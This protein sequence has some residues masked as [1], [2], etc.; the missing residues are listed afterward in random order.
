MRTEV[1]DT[2]GEGRWFEFLCI[3]TFPG[4]SR[5]FV[6]QSMS[7]PYSSWFL[8]IAV[9]LAPFFFQILFHIVTSMLCLVPLSSLKCT[10][11]FPFT[12]T[13][14]A[15][16]RKNTPSS[17]LFL[18]G[19]VSVALPYICNQWA[20]WWIECL[21]T[22]SVVSNIH[23]SGA[24][25][26]SGLWMNAQSIINWERLKKWKKIILSKGESMCCQMPLFLFVNASV[27]KIK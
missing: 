5:G 6:L 8:L 15:D 26:N 21:Q 20:K 4:Y 27:C 7:L 10:F 13:G 3:E 25:T 24:L 19:M 1:P 14:P 23:L 22:A 16:L 12:T 18:L 9:S 2:C 17:F 11:H